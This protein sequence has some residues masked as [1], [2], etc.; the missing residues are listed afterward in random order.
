MTE[1]TLQFAHSEMGLIVEMYP[2]IALN[3]SEIIY[4]HE[5]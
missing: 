3:Y 4:E 5:D 2:K 1:D